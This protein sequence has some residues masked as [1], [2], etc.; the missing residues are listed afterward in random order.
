[1]IHTHSLLL[2]ESEHWGGWVSSGGTPDILL[3]DRKRFFCRQVSS[4]VIWRQ[5]QISQ[6]RS[7]LSSNLI[8]LRSRPIETTRNQVWVCVRLEE[9]WLLVLYYLLSTLT[10]PFIGKCQQ[11]KNS[12]KTYAENFPDQ[13][14][15]KIRY[16]WLPA[17]VG[18]N[19]SPPQYF[20]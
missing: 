1:M 7:G 18:L 15:A 13:A 17:N 8:K 20:L 14:V 9:Q 12:S 10:L 3:A 19:E 11:Y 2:V 5:I 6:G 4:A 16:T